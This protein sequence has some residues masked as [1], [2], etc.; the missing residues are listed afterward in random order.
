MYNPY[1]IGNI[2]TNSYDYN[3]SKSDNT[4]YNVPTHNA[5]NTN[6]Y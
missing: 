4:G 6:G 5:N 2:T 1:S 3:Y